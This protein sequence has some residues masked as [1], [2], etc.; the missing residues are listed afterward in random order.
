MSKYKDISADIGDLF[1]NETIKVT[2]YSYSRPAWVFWQGY[3]NGLIDNG[4][5]HE[6][7]IAVLQS[8]DVRWMLDDKSD[9][10]KELGYNLARNQS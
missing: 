2:M 4:L 9:Q 1:P 6:Q 3:Y 5:T 7:A 8:R 10:I